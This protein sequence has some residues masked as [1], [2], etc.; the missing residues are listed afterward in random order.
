MA[1]NQLMSVNDDKTVTWETLFQ[2]LIWLILL[3]YDVHNK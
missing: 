1:L 2:C 3:L